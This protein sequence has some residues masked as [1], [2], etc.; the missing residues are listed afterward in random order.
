[1]GHHTEGKWSIHD[2]KHHDPGTL[3]LISLSLVGRSS[4]PEVMMTCWIR[5]S[6]RKSEDRNI[7]GMWINAET[8]IKYSIQSTYCQLVTVTK[9]I[10]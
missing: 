3:L 7:L 9:H 6:K 8:Y 1:M 4:V 10:C 5:Y 2:P